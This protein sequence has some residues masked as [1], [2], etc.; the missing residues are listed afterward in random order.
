[1]L[2]CRR[3]NGKHSYDRVAEILHDILNEFSLQ[4]EQIVSTITDNG[5]N[6]V[7]AFQEFGYDMDTEIDSDNEGNLNF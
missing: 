6:F 4:R 2:S 1:V 5:T 3:F 7:K